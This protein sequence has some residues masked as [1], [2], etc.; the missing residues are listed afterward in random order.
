MKILVKFPTRERPD[1]FVTTIAEYIK[2]SESYI[3]YIIS[4]D[5]DDKEMLKLSREFNMQHIAKMTYKIGKRV[6]KIEA[7]NRDIDGDW[8]ILVLASDDMRC[9]VQGWD[10]IIKEKMGNDLDQCLWF[11]DGHQT[12]ICTMS[13]M[14]RKR[15]DKYGYIYH[16]SYVSLFCDNEFTE[17]HKPKFFEQCLF[18]HYHPAWNSKGVNDDLYRYNESLW[19][20]D[21]ENYNK[22]KKLGFP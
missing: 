12:R 22:R 7:C 8:D 20:V 21:E 19:G 18:E 5:E 1:Q 9:M 2:N 14:G 4:I 6:S 15:Y 16:P 11:N 3:E 13:I 10:T 17:V